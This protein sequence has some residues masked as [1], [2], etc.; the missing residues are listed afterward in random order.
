M[1]AVKKTGRGSDGPLALFSGSVAG[2][3]LLLG[4]LAFIDAFAL[5]FLIRLIDDRVWFLAVAVLVVTIGVNAAFLSRKLYPFRWFSPGLSLM[6]LMVAYPTLFTIYT[7]FTNYSTGNLLN[8]TQVIERIETKPEYRYLPDGEQYYDAIPFRNEDGKY[9]LWLVG[10]SDRQAYIVTEDDEIE[11]VTPEQAGIEGVEWVEDGDPPIR[12]EGYE[13]LPPEDAAAVLA[14]RDTLD[15]GYPV[16]EVS[17]RLIDGPAEVP[18]GYALD[19]GTLLFVDNTGRRPKEYQAYLFRAADGDDLLLYAVDGRDTLLARPDGRVVI[20][21]QP[22]TIGGYRM[23]SNRE[24][25]A[26]TQVLPTLTFGERDDPIYIDPFSASRAGRFRPRFLYDERQDA[27][28][29][30]D[31]GA[32]Y[33]PVKGTFTLD[34]ASVSVEA[35]DELPATLSPGYYVV[36]GLDNFERL[37]TDQRLRG[38]FVRVFLW[39]I[40]HAFLTVLLTFSLGLALALLLNDRLIPARKIWRSLILIPYAIPAFIST[41]VWRG[42]LN[43]RLGLINDTLERIVGAGNAPGWYSDPMWAKIGILLI[44]LWLG[45]PYMML[46]CTGA[47]QSI[48]QDMYEAAQVDGA[49]AFQR[50]RH[51]TLPLLLVAVGP[52]LIASFAYNFNNFTVI[53][54]FN[55]GGPP[56]ANSSVPAGHTDILITY[57]YEQ[58]FGSGGGT[59]YAFASAITLVIFLLVAA[60]TIFN[61][62]FT[63]SWEETS[64][65]V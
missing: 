29:E 50:F 18:A 45:F 28:V 31:T 13:Y 38:P 17:I 34:R 53:E 36:V 8:K 56:I 48:P 51:L 33:R 6:V 37:L 24:R 63:R 15:Y 54:L 60:I 41:L 35:A 12:V 42:L 52:L 14:E 4:G 65:N 20:N 1:N 11:P 16:G 44:Q 22:Y 59:N 47:L 55:E 19:P 7:A 27:F 39:T 62:R 49:N 25:T 46:I 40:A 30:Q 64:R 32:I 5:W 9:L 23:L 2:S 58:A 26:I 61:Y 3:L 43:P 57:T 10:R 21:G